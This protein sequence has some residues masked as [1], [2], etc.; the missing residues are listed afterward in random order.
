[1]LDDGIFDSSKRVGKAI[2]AAQKFK[3]KNPLLQK[4]KKQFMGF[5]S[6]H[7]ELY[8][9]RYGYQVEEPQEVERKA[10]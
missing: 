1:M 3:E 2:E 9:T 6:T 4:M 8:E 7:R 10:E 5:A